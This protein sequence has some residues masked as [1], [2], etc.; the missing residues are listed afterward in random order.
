MVATSHSS[1]GVQ[2]RSFVRTHVGSRLRLHVRIDPN[3]SKDGQTLPDSRLTDDLEQFNERSYPALYFSGF[4]NSLPALSLLMKSDK[5]QPPHMHI[6]YASKREGTRR[7]PRIRFLEIGTARIR[8]ERLAC[9]SGPAADRRVHGLC[10]VSS[11]VPSLR[12]FQT[13]FQ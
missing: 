7:L 8:R 12:M 2:I 13:G 10:A 3:V 6:A 11:N 4:L 5:H 1:R 9:L